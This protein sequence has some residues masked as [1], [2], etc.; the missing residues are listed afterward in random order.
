MRINSRLIYMKV[1]T[2]ILQ[3]TAFR[4]KKVS[5]C[6]QTIY[7]VLLGCLRLWDKTQDKQWQR[8]ADELCNILLKI[9]KPDGG[10][11][12]G[13]DF[14]FG[15][16]HKKGEST[17]P[18]LIGLIALVEYHKRFA[19]DNVKL[20]AQ[21]TALWIKKNSIRIDEDKW[22]IPYAPYSTKKV[23]VYN[24]TS[25]AVGAL[26]AYLSV[27]PDE[28]LE[29]IYH[30]MVNYLYSSLSALNEQPGKFW[31][32][33]DQ[34]RNDLT[35][36]QRKKIDYYHQMQQ[37]EMHAMA[38]LN[39][40]SK[41]QL[42]IIREAS[43]HIANKQNELGVIPYLN[44]SVPIHV[45]GYCSCASGFIYSSKLIKEKK[46]EYFTRALKILEWLET[47]SWNSNYFFA[48]LSENG[49]V[50]D[51]RFYV[52]SDAWVFNTFA[53]AVKENIN[54]DKYLHICDKCYRK[55][56]SVDFSGIENHASNR[57]IRTFMKIIQAASSVNKQ[58]WQK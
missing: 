23:M 33:S 48:I 2:T 27:F 10:F 50:I 57:R 3:S 5:Y 7:Q 58:L 31:Y 20:A 19:N 12:I 46:D 16:L 24:G 55:M 35:E 37:V 17:S 28:E 51:N 54:K 32:Y 11:D 36:V 8:R 26:G 34:T 25:F 6:S 42:D 47:Y 22:A 49:Q 52:R 4:P 1:L 56:E 44:T 14:N 29:V 21:K 45:W 15:M 53:L 39:I 18:E 13:Y 40:N 30:G 9:Q 41:K 38:E 43:Q